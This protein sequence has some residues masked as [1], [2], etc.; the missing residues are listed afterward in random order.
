MPVSVSFSHRN[1]ERKKHFPG[2]Q[3]TKIVAQCGNT[4]G[5]SVF[6]DLCFL[7]CKMRTLGQLGC[8][9]L[10]IL[11][12][13]DSE[14]IMAC[15]CRLH[16]TYVFPCHSKFDFHCEGNKTLCHRVYIIYQCFVGHRTRSPVWVKVDPA[17]FFCCWLCTKICMFGIRRE[18]LKK[19][20]QLLPFS[21]YTLPVF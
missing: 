6:P 16:F 13:Q 1:V 10:P 2:N 17:T 15:S 9:S 4:W 14:K 7:I 5:H 8:K 12:P 11:K 18:S 21:T 3:E 20:L 19:L